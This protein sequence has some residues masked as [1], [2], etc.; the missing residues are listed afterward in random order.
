[1]VPIKFPEYT[2]DNLIHIDEG[3]D[4]RGLVSDEEQE[5]EFMSKRRSESYKGNILYYMSG[6][7]ISCNMLTGS[8]PPQI[9]Y[10]SSIHTLNISNN[11]L[12]GSIPESFSNLKDVESLDISYNRLS[13]H[14]PSKLVELYSLALFSVAHNNLSGITP[15]S[16]YQFA[17]FG[18]SSYE[19]N[20]LLCGSPLESC[21]FGTATE[22]EESNF[23]DNFLWSF[24]A[25]FVVAFLSVIAI[26]YFNPDFGSRTFPC[27]SFFFCI[28]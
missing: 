23:K 14:I 10:L 17:T 22:E 18:P 6:I 2:S 28:A 15:E 16:K 5:V 8:I 11:H 7:D 1:M 21:T 26:I 4:I 9:G 20:P 25:S 12:T 3:I 27:T 19:G 13:G 24:A